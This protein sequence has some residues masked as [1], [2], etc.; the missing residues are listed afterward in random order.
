[1]LQLSHGWSCTAQSKILHWGTWLPLRPHT[2]KL[3]SRDKLG[4]CWKG[5]EIKMKSGCQ[6][7]STQSWFQVVNMYLK[8][9]HAGRL[10]RSP[11]RWSS[12]RLLHFLSCQHGW[13][14]MRKRKNHM[15]PQLQHKRRTGKGD[16]E[17]YCGIWLFETSE[18]MLLLFLLWAF[19]KNRARKKESNYKNISTIT[20]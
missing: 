3:L 10:Q 17:G 6:C 15:L 4:S 19:F 11:R 7:C 13:L 14:Q 18:Q 9:R 20:A 5:P 2:L 16:R 12:T 8:D 1:M